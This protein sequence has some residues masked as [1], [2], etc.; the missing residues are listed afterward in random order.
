MTRRSDTTSLQLCRG[1][2]DH[3]GMLHTLFP[4]HAQTSLTLAFSH[5]AFVF[6][7]PSEQ[8]APTQS[9]PEDLDLSREQT[10]V[11]V[12]C[13][14]PVSSADVDY[15]APQLLIE[16][17]IPLL[18]AGCREP[19]SPPNRQQYPISA[20]G[21][22][23]FGG[24]E[25]VR[26]VLQLPPGGLSPI[27]FPT[28]QTH[29]STSPLDAPELSCT[30]SVS[31]ESG[32]Y[33]PRI[34]DKIHHAPKVKIHTDN[35]YPV[36]R[37]VSSESLQS[38]KET[39][40]ETIYS[41]NPLVDITKLRVRSPTH[42]CLY[43]GA[44]FAGTQKSGRSSYDVNVTIVVRVPPPLSWSPQ[45]NQLLPT[46]RIGCRLLV[47]VFVWLSADTWPDRGL[48]RAHNLL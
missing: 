44:T 3:V 28:P 23:S 5:T 18:C 37:T 45:S 38:Q 21:R 15:P 1:D 43:P 36:S 17:D 7:M 4:P 40:H 26:P 12:V 34:S 8:S 42:H 9:Q 33:L 11:C 27:P 31:S 35:L 29:P 16:T 24:A 10:K 25:F 22:G 6:L 46:L 2:A 19:R 41:P 30:V 39:R 20:G 13:K 47:I 32:S 48:A 14:T